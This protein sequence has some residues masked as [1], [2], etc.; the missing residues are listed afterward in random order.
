MDDTK[1]TKL[2]L[3]YIAC[4][5]REILEDFAL[6]NGDKELMWCYLVDLGRRLPAL[7]MGERIR[8]NLVTK[9][10]SRVWL[11]REVRGGRLW[12]RADS[13]SSITKGLVSLLVRVFSG[14]LVEAVAKAN[15]FLLPSVSQLVGVQRSSGFYEMW[16]VVQHFVRV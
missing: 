14:Q 11:V 13:E 5:Q 2:S 16:G 3:Q 10:L 1:D 4:A 7:S 12:L 8:E 9:C 6:F 15:F